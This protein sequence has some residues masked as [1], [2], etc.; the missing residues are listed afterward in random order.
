MPEVGG[1]T[2]PVQRTEKLDAGTEPPG[3]VEP[4]NDK[5]T[6]LSTRVMVALPVSVRLLK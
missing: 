5:F 1:V 3:E 6:E 2:K 4:L